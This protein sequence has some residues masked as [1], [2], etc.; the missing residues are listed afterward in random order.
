LRG[1]D[2]RLEM[3]ALLAIA[4]LVLLYLGLTLVSA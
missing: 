2:R 1:K 3:I 4:T